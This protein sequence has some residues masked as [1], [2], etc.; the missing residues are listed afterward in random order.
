LYKDRDLCR[1]IGENSQIQAQNFA[2]PCY[3]ENFAA[4]Y[5]E[6]IEK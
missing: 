5:A 1:H 3:F 2:W 6:I 4:A